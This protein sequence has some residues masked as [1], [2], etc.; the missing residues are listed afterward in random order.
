MTGPQIQPAASDP[1]TALQDTPP[2]SDL[3]ELRRLLDERKKIM[4]ARYHECEPE[5]P[6]AQF[7]RIMETPEAWL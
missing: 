2:S 3:I 1:V 7:T 4:E 5:E 6:S